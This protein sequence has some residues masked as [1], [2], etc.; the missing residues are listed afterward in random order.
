[1][2]YAI[3]DLETTSFEKGHPYSECNRLVCTGILKNGQDPVV[4]F[5][6]PTPHIEQLIREDYVLVGSNIKFDIAWLRNSGLEVPSYTRIWDIALAHFMLMSQKAVMPSVDEM[7]DYHGTTKKLDIVKKEYWEKG[8]DTDKVPKEILS[9]YQIGDLRST[10]EI[11]L[12]QYKEFKK[13][14]KLYQLFKIHCKDLIVLEEIQRNGLYYNNNKAGE[15]KHALE[16]EIEELKARL[17]EHAPG[18]PI[19]WNSGDHLS[20]ILFGGVIQCDSRVPDGVFKTGKKVGELKYKIVVKEYMMPGLVKPKKDWELLKEGFYST[21]E[22]VLRQINHKVAKLLL[23]YAGLVKL[24]EYF[25]K[26][27]TL[28]SGKAWKDDIVHAT[29]NQTVAVTGR[30]SSSNPNGQNL[31]PKVLQY[32]ESRNKC[33]LTADAKALEWVAAVFLAQD[34]VGTHELITGLDQHSLNQEAFGLPTRGIAKVF[35]FRLIFGG[36]YYHNDPDFMAVSKDKA[37]WDNVI[38]A[39][40]TKYKGIAKWDKDIVQ[41]AMLNGHTLMPTGRTYKYEPY[42]RKGE[43]FWPITTIL[44]YPRQGLGADLMAIIRVLVWR[45][46]NDQQI[47]NTMIC[48]TV[49]DDIKVDTDYPELIKGIYHEAFAEAPKAFEQSFGIPFNLPLRCELKIGTNLLELE[50]YP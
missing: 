14:P 46:I 9:E 23:S 11:F 32:F 13:Y 21:K 34:P 16:S 35:L 40:Y 41:E 26:I 36:K 49:H 20:C 22:S 15:A 6:N 42:L 37:Y 7:A 5:E 1:M 48:S 33:F 31:P 18:V 45:K 43:H 4:L 30:T 29:I 38:E 24:H 39:F 2:R 27:P 12:I 8:I 3:V 10:E 28:I 19:N 44:N 47:P 17:A 50:E 25:V